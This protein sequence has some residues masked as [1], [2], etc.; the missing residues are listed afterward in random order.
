MRSVASAAGD[1]TVLDIV[2]TDLRVELLSLGAAI[3]DGHPAFSKARKM[4]TMLR[5]SR[6]R[7]TVRTTR[8][9]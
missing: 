3:R 6:G 7:I 4:A 8:P 9:R 1:F 5:A 2:V